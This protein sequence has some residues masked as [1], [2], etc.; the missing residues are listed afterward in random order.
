MMTSQLTHE[1][2]AAAA[3]I[4]VEEGA[5]YGAAKRRAARQLARGAVR[6]PDLPDND[7]IEDEVRQYLDL[8]CADTQ[9]RELAVLRGIALA[10]MERLA[11]FRPHLCGAV[12][13]GTATRA[14]AVHLELY[15]DDA[16]AAEIELINRRIDYRVATGQG[17]QGQAVDQLIV[18]VTSHELQTVVPVCLT[19]LD[20]DDLRGRLRPDAR[21]RSERGDLAAVRRLLDNPAREADLP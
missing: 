1:I 14:S 4:V 11:D 6:A 2:A 21:G 7:L 8:F 20:H 9:P 13:R 19:V 10:W 15:A 16:K 17:P 18:D 3:R 5:D 12:W